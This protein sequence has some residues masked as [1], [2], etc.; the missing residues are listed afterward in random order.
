MNSPVLPACSDWEEIKGR[1]FMEKVFKNSKLRRTL[2]ILLVICLLF[3]TAGAASNEKP[4]K[5]VKYTQKAIKSGT[6]SYYYYILEASTGTKSG[7][8]VMFFK[9]D[10][11]DSSNEKRTEYIFP[12]IDGRARSLK[13]ITTA[14]S[15]LSSTPASKVDLTRFTNGTL[16]NFKLPS[17]DAT[18]KG[19]RA[20]SSDQYCFTTEKAIKSIDGL[21]FFARSAG[22]W[23]CK[24]INIYSVDALSKDLSYNGTISNY[25]V[26]DF[27]GRLLARANAEGNYVSWDISDY[28]TFTKTKNAMLTLETGLE[29]PYVSYE[30]K[31]VG[32]A[33]K[34]S[35]IEGGGL[36]GMLQPYNEKKT[37]QNIKFPDVFIMDVEYKDT[38]GNTVTLELPVVRLA[39]LTIGQQGFYG[40]SVEGFL[41]QGDTIIFSTFLRGC[42]DV[43]DV[44]LKMSITNSDDNSIGVFSQDDTRNTAMRYMTSPQKRMPSM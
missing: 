12:H 9:V 13:W 39:M 4:K 16:D 8:D 42:A 14:V 10:Y 18:V 32:I 27:E 19:L 24:G 7:D 5:T 35:D 26:I 43:K 20:F 17:N 11:T 44:K 29:T 3:G 15:T 25:P 6:G 36:E 34:I 22:S 38:N 1:L 23:S 30:G 33:I 37:I 40:S 41:Q 2:S 21:C 28:V 31:N